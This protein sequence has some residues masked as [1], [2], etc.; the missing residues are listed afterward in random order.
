M[1]ARAKKQPSV[2]SAAVAGAVLS[3]VATII[4]MSVVIVATSPST[5]NALSIPLIC[6]GFAAAAYGAFFTIKAL[7]QKMQAEPDTK[8]AFS[9]SA[10]LVFASLL[11]IVLVASAALREWFG[12]AGSITAAA[13]AGLVDTHAAAISIASLVASGH[14][15]PADAV[16]PILAGLSTNTITKLVFATTSGDRAYAI[17]VIPGLVLVAMSAW[18]GMLII[19]AVR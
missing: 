17:R 7:R 11:S 2:L 18:L 1:G 12:E 5:L 10:A 3:T 19:S 9:L 13:V 15:S 14:M 6:S 16:V 4:Q 8:Q